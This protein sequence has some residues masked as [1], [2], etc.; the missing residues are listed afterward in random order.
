MSLKNFLKSR[1]FLVQFVLAFLLVAG[2]VSIT[3]QQIKSY[4][5]HGESFPVPDLTGLSANEIE[6]VT[7]QYNLKYQI[8][9][10]VHIENA[11]PGTVVEQTPEPGF[12]VKTNRVVLVTINSIIPEKVVLPKLTDI[13]FR[14]ALG[15]IDN[16][17]IALGE[18]T[19]A[20][21]EYNNLV[22]KVVQDTIEI[23]QGDLIPKGSTIDLVI[24]TNSGIQD[25]PLPDLT[26]L[27]YKEADSLLGTYM[28]NTGISIWDET[29]I[30]SEDTLAAFIWKQYPSKNIRLVS[31]G[32]SIDLWLTLD[33]LKVLK[34]SLK[35]TK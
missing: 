11:E 22:L 13:S 1:V 9:D 25:T 2:I 23:F 5:N 6:A 15:L 29:V 33:S 4:T 32:T 10:S 8:I 30:T 26:M 14:Q 31:L 16:C 24:G 12:K 35:E 7:D 21:S 18:I 34:P 28:L 17:G 27:T 19:Y 3:L 20:P